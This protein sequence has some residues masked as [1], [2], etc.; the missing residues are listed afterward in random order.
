MIC[1]VAGHITDYFA[2]RRTTILI[3][4]LALL[5]STIFLCIGSSIGILIVG[6]ILQGISSAL[7]WTAALTLVA[8]TVE[9]H[10]IGAIMGV[11]SLGMNLALLLAPLIGGA[12]FENKGYYSVFGFTFGLLVV[13]IA[14][15]VAIIE[16]NEAVRW[17]NTPIEEYWVSRYASDGTPSIHPSPERT[18]FPDLGALEYHF[19]NQMLDESPLPPHLSLLQQL[20]QK[21]SVLLDRRLQT[22]LGATLA[23]ITLLA[24]FDAVLP[25]FVHESF[26]WGPERAG[27]IFI[28]IVAPSFLSIYLGQLTD[29][30]GPKYL[31]CTGFTVAIPALMAL[32]LITSDEAGHIALLCVLL[33]VI[34]TAMAFVGTPLMVEIMLAVE[35]IENSR[36][37][38][39]GHRGPIAQ[40]YALYSLSVFGGLLA[41]PLL[42]GLIEKVA[43]WN[44]MTMVFGILS[45][46][47]ALLTFLFAGGKVTGRIFHR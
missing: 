10:E 28:P 42:G 14:W 44:T 2:S 45:G 11:C 29:K 32:R 30:Y 9:K 39:F 13:D 26:S 40:A 19:E 7:T 24:S 17:T 5:G 41:G 34:S 31:V 37:G 47:M 6:R 35:A 15:R 18:Q 4:F 25:H 38:I 20:S 12:L 1:P 36:P 43:G 23:Q 21:I 22:S 3:A 27:L 8:D 46:L 16:G 33:A